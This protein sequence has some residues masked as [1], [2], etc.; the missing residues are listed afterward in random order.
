MCMYIKDCCVFLEQRGKTK[1]SKSD[2]YE[3]YQVFCVI[4]SLLHVLQKFSKQQYKTCFIHLCFLV[5]VG[6]K[7]KVLN[8]TMSSCCTWRQAAF[9][10]CCS[11]FSFLHFSFFLFHSTN[12]KDIYL[13]IIL[14]AMN[15]KSVFSIHLQYSYRYWELHRCYG[16]WRTVSEVLQQSNEQS[17][18]CGDEQIID[19]LCPQRA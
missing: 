7:G 16:K 4:K 11:L 17:T 13:V 10:F 6:F 14:A 8:P 12:T 18:W 1:R 2:F 9:G 5:W 19:S 15:Y 3:V